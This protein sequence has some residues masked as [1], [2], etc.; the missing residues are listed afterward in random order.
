MGRIGL[1]LVPWKSSL[2]IKMQKLQL[3]RP[4]FSPEPALPHF[5]NKFVNEIF[6]IFLSNI[7]KEKI[8]L[9]ILNQKKILKVNFQ[10]QN[11]HLKS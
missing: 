9:W 11:K 10:P 8:L 7:W 1:P 3:K 5:L 4:R 2:F 6:E